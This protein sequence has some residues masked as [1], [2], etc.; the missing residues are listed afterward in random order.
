MI[1]KHTSLASLSQNRVFCRLQSHI[2]NESDRL[3]PKFYSLKAIISCLDM[4][5]MVP[6]RG[7]HEAAS[8]SSHIC[9]VWMLPKTYQGVVI[10]SRNGI[11]ILCMLIS[12]VGIRQGHKNATVSGPEF[13]VNPRSGSGSERIGRRE[14][15]ATRYMV[16]GGRRQS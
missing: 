4:I 16:L 9:E 14:D 11:C 7:L 2:H 13:C 5:S 8:L 10:A 12:R 6:G 15:R 1:L 3:F